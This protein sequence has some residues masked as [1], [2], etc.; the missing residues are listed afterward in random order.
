MRTRNQEYAQKVFQ[1]IENL[2]YLKDSDEAKKYGNAAHNLPVL[3]R[4]AGLCQALAFMETRSEEPISKLLDHLA[5]AV[6]KSNK[7]TL[8]SNSRSADL[9][10]YTRL[11][12][13]ILQA[14]VW[15]KRFAQSVLEVNIT[16]GGG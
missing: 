16:E 1:A 11:T 14:L 3:I 10:E 6:G 12:R 13:E 7:A 15:F 2:G 5:Q 8:L 4:S 9:L